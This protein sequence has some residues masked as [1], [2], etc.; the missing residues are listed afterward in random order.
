MIPTFTQRDMRGFDPRSAPHA[1]VLIGI[2]VVGR[3]NHVRVLLSR[4]AWSCSASS[5]QQ[6]AVPVP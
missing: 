3:V 6:E 5:A 2:G 4:A 1:G